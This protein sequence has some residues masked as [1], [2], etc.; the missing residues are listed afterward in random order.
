MSNA[1]GQVVD[2]D[3]S[4]RIRIDPQSRVAVARQIAAG[5]EAMID[6]GQLR[7][8]DRL[9]TQKALA[10]RLAVHFRT[11]REAYL[12]LEA[13]GLVDQTQGRGTFVTQLHRARYRVVVLMPPRTELLRGI[14]NA[15]YHQ[16]FL[17]G[18]ESFFTDQQF[19]LS[20]LTIPTTL[21]T[22]DDVQ[23]WADRI[24]DNYDGLLSTITSLKPLIQK[25]A[26]ANFPVA[27]YFNPPDAPGVP[28]VRCD[29]K[30]GIYRATQHLIDAGR[31]RIGYL[32]RDVSD[33]FAMPGFEG[34]FSALVERQCV[35]DP[36][37]TIRCKDFMRD[38][39]WEKTLAAAA[40]EGRLGDA[41][42]ADCS[43]AAYWA[44]RAV[45][46]AGKRVPEDVAIVGVD[47]A[48]GAVESDPAMTWLYIPR[49]EIAQRAAA[50][51]ARR[52]TTGEV[53]SQEIVVEPRLVPGRS[54][55]V[56][57]GSGE[58]P[59][60]VMDQSEIRMRLDV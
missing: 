57:D 27:A 12:D 60:N 16:E 28:L 59:L 7:P 31:T 18:L 54:C 47:E 40:Q 32:G 43:R 8:G 58:I 13:R 49:F 5:L 23:Y 52:L 3:F 41:I 26:D 48:M 15:L 1:R 10:D 44:I 51:L 56:F 25:L 39:A 46:Q 20:I 45:K 29:V 21:A 55:G 9:P 36:A 2:P 30:L 33:R 38:L 11:I 42:V 14:R 53:E 6:A 34:Y 19:S 4:E 17:A 22:Q 50:L 24:M 37:L 35:Y